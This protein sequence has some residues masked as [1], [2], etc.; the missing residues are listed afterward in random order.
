[1]LGSSLCSFCI[2]LPPTEFAPIDEYQGIR[3]A[4]TTLAYA[5]CGSAM[6]PQT[7][8]L[9]VLSAAFL[10]AERACTFTFRETLQYGCVA[11]RKPSSKSVAIGR[12][13][14]FHSAAS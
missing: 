4:A 9:N 7:A 11:K 14:P 1:V 10:S 12:Q 5:I 6:R 3:A 2:V 8:S 13:C